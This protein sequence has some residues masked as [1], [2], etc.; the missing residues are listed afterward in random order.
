M[1]KL[2]AAG[3]VA[4]AAMSL[5]A[6]A[7]ADTTV[8]TITAGTFS[9]VE[10]RCTQIDSLFA[11]TD[12]TYGRNRP[13]PVDP[14]NPDGVPWMGPLFG[15][16]HYAPG[17]PGAVLGYIPTSGVEV[18]PDSL[19]G[20]FI[21][22]PPDGKIQAVVTGT[23]SINDNGTPGNAA[24]DKI[25]SAFSIGPIV[26]NVSTGATTRA[27]Q[28]WTSMNHVMAEITVSSAAANANGGIDYVIGSR[29]FPTTRCSNTDAADCFPTANSSNS[30]SQG[31][32]WADIPPKQ[33]GIERSG[34]MGDPDLGLKAPVQPPP[35]IPKG[36]VGGQSTATFVGQTCSATSVP[37]IDD[38]ISSPLVWGGGEPAGFDN[39]I[40]QVSTDSSG[41]ITSALAYY[42]EEYRI[43][44]GGAPAGYD[45]SSDSGTY[46]FTAPA[47]VPTARNFPASV[48][49]NSSSNILDAAA[50]CVS[51]PGPVTVSIVTQPANG[52]ATEANNTIIYTPNADYVGPDPIVYQCASG[53]IIPP[54]GTISV[55]VEEDTVPVAPDGAI[56][57]STQGA[58]PGP[59][60]TG[61]VNTAI[62]SPPYVPGNTPNAWSIIAPLATNG[63]ATVPPAGT[64]ITYTP[65]ATFFTGT[66]T[67]NYQITDSN[68]DTDS[69]VIT[70]TIPNVVPLLADG[71]ITTDQD[72]ASSPQVLLITPG[73]G[74]VAQSPVAVTTGATSGTC[75]VTGT[76]A[77]PTL[78][79]TPAAGSFGTDSCVLTIT[80]GDGSTDTG[81]FSITVTG[82]SDELQ[83]PGGGS[84]VDL[85]SL[86]LLGA[87]PLLRRRRRV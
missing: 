2:T 15:G 82:V 51:F 71:T 63:T 26:R 48:L 52:L 76:A 35:A 69:G 46:S 55:T 17:S 77:A 23:L 58:A 50:N 73:N 21:P 59:G 25:S 74:S 5:S 31:R 29:G 79:Y 16:G 13:Q 28:S 78:T 49:E 44:F 56:S 18:P 36:N 70:V 47:P 85:W 3:I 62:P 27:N 60:T 38:C 54:P 39:I 40:M 84:A 87:L 24:D 81:T 65:S 10:Q 12:C 53:S 45:N 57:I 1:R 72:R 80:D 83:L 64:T 11:N 14:E 68:G 66:D 19:T 20:V 42:S 37:P 30:F 61:T 33:V 8:Y 22:A 32:F 75:A 43:A 41:A 6:Q 34:L 67:V 4:A 9:E 7:G 86:S